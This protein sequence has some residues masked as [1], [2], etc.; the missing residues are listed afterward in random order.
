[1]SERVTRHGVTLLQ[2]DVLDAIDQARG[3][4]LVIA[5]PPWRYANTGG[6]RSG[7]FRGAAKSHYRTAH[8]DDIAVALDLAWEVAAPDAYL[9]LWW[10]WPL[11]VELLPIFHQA[12]RWTYKSG[13]VWRKQG[14]MGI[15]FHS[16]GVCEPWAVLTKGRA[17][18][19][20]R[21]FINHGEA[22]RRRHSEKPVE[23]LEEMVKVY[24]PPGGLVLS[25]YSGLFPEGR[26]CLRAGRRAIGAELDPERYRAACAALSQGAQP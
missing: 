25:L 14:P 21:S 4:E 20:H 7:K 5:D 16:R 19:Q 12:T 13:G 18:P 8:V 23:L 11:L 22:P 2:G 6:V 9:V 10:T 3:A 1:M 17:K 15:G 24:C 26:A